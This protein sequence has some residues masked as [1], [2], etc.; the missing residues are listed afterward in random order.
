MCNEKALNFG[1]KGKVY[2][3]VN[4]IIIVTKFPI[5]SSKKT[6]YTKKHRERA[7]TIG[8]SLFE[9]RNGAL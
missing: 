3:T 4:K 7:W 5:S 1:T 8:L 6:N 9:A 2:I